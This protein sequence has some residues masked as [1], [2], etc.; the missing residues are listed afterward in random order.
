MKNTL[1]RVPVALVVA[2]ALTS[3]AKT[4][5]VDAATGDDANTGL[6]PGLAFATLQHA[7]DT[8][9]AGSTV[10][11]APGLYAPLSTA[12]KLTFKSTD[13]RTST[14]IDG[15]GVYSAN[16]KKPAFAFRD[17]LSATRRPPPWACPPP[18]SSASRE[19]ATGNIRTVA[20]FGNLSL[21]DV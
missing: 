19:L 6:K 1:L 20:T 5:Y 2:L 11:V 21:S 3:S 8:A 12:K 4:D 10:F 13:G 17:G 16:A 14:T 15:A 7:A 9:A 18:A